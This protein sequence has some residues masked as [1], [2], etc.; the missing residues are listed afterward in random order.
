V[1]VPGKAFQPSLLFDDKA[2]AYQIGPP[3]K[4][5]LLTLPTNIRLGCKELPLKLTT[6]VKC[7]KAQALNWGFGDL[8]LRPKWKN[9]MVFVISCLDKQGL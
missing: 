1:F 8:Q 7:F 6:V 4:G 3:F 2:G 9:A 5:R